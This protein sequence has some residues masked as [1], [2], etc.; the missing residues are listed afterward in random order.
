MPDAL[1]AISALETL[2]TDLAFIEALRERLL[3]KLRQTARKLDAVGQERRGSG[4]NSD[5]LAMVRGLCRTALERIG[6]KLSA[7]DAISED[8]ITALGGGMGQ[9]TLI[10]DCRDWLYRT[11][12]VFAPILAEWD[13]APAG[14][15]EQFW[16]RLAR[17]HRLLAPRF[18]ALQ[19][20][21]HFRVSGSAQ[22]PAPGRAR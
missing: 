16:G 13:G 2:I 6:A 17:T 19:E 3:V 12:R 9:K 4:A 22:N 5:M 18:M 15:D 20:W 1:H 8:I 7:V 14:I 10:R 11:Q 21:K